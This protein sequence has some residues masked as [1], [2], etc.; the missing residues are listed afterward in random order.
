MGPGGKLWSI[1]IGEKAERLLE[2]S[3]AQVDSETAEFCR[4]FGL[5]VE[6]LVGDSRK[7]EVETGE[8]DIVFVDGDHTY[9][10][11]RADVNRFGARLRVGGSL[12]LDDVSTTS[13]S[14]TTPESVGLLVGELEAA[15]DFRLVKSVDR[16]AH[17][18]RVR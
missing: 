18:E 16:L 10:G 8:V 13:S 12:L 4:R 14:P 9:E 2:I 3:A 5:D 6:L 11:V 1:D 15:G 7:I 17:L